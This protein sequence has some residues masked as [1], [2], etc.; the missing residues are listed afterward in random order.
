MLENMAVISRAR[1]PF[2]TCIVSRNNIHKNLNLPIIYLGRGVLPENLRREPYVVK[3]TP[4][5]LVTFWDHY[6]VKYHEDWLSR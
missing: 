3:V 5:S 4:Q 2:L 6:V 1:H